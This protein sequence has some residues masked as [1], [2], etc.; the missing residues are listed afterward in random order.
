MSQENVALI[1]AAL[2]HFATTGELPWDDIHEHV[3]VEDH[4]IMDARDYRGHAGFGRWVE[5]WSA[6]WSEDAVE[7][8]EFIDADPRVLVFVRQKT[9]GHGSGVVLERDDAMLFEVREGKIARLDY[10]NNR[11]QGRAAA[12]LEV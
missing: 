4:D 8:Q 11:A 5:D 12:G 6:A 3:V 7:P 9:T 2:E 10:Y 1:Q